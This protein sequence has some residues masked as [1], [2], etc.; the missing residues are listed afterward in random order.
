MM[1]PLAALLLARNTPRLESNGLWGYISMNVAATPKEY[2]YGVSLYSSA[3]PLIE[4]PLRNFQIGLASTWILPDNRE[5]NTPLV[6][7]GTVARDSM[8]ERG[9]SFRDVFQTI[10]GG[11]GFWASNRFWSPTA[12]F[13]MN[14]TADGYNHEISSPGWQFGGHSENVDAPALAGDQM[15]IAQLS[16]HI[17]V[18][19]DGVT[20]RKDTCGELFGYAWMALPLI[21]AKSTPVATGDQCWT[22]FFNTQNFRGP[23]AFYIPNT[24][25]R[26]SRTYP[27]AVG[28]GLDARPGIPASGAIEINTVPRFLS[29]DSNG[30]AYTRIPRLQFPADRNG[31]TVLMHNL[32]VYSKAALW[33][34]VES[35][36]AGGAAAPSTFAA[37]G[38]LTPKVTPNP[39][40]IHQGPKH[41]LV[42]GCDR[43]VQTT[44][45][46]ATTFGLQWTPA[47]LSIWKPDVWK[48][49]IPEYCRLLGSQLTA[50]N[51]EDVPDDTGLQTAKF[52]PADQTHSYISP[53]GPN[54]VWHKPGPKA[55]PFTAKLADGSVV[56]YYW[57]RFIDQ[58]SLQDA[59]LSPGEKLRLQAIAEKIQANWTTK[60][61][62]MAPPKM[63]KLAWLDPAQLVTPPRGLE[64]GYVPIVTRQSP[65]N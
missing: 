5:I 36:L 8:P 41:Q 45:I 56:T 64:I 35:W 27:P 28:R 39:F 4:E 6:P 18:P 60:K 17:L 7:H 37:A 14:G 9:P 57:Y 52:T 15:G 13:R 19:P 65:A 63:G 3:W 34:E 58:P 54:D 43:W 23:V 61:E 38:S 50:V 10:E 62:Y 24:W 11:L 1:I 25:S 48:G 26:M 53:S 40:A 16:S 46:D 42:E 49:V 33:D 21:A 31:Q 51:P 30:V 44:N 47:A 2:G 55:G 12:K 32:T 22:S 29:E 20:L 59:N